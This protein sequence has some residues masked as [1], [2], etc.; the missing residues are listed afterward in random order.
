[1]VYDILRK[2][3]LLIIPTFKKTKKEMR[4]IITSVVTGFIGLTF[5]EL[6]SFF[7]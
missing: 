4:G 2:E 5:K 6:S 1:M 7:T 3:I